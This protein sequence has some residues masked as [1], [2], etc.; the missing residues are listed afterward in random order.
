MTNEINFWDMILAAIFFARWKA[1]CLSQRVTWDESKF[2]HLQ[3]RSKRQ[4]MLFCPHLL[5]ELSNKFDMI[6]FES[7]F[8]ALTVDEISKLIHFKNFGGAFFLRI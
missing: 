5:F 2:V 7:A 8:F 3:H 6:L 4:M 1:L